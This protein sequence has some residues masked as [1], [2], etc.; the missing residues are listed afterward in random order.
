MSG[1]KIFNYKT[2]QIDELLTYQNPTKLRGNVYICN[3]DK[4]F[5]ILIQTKDLI[6]K[7]GIVENDKEAYIELD[8]RGTDLQ[9]F[10][11]NIDKY[12]IN[13]VHTK[14]KE[15][16]DQEVPYESIQEFYISNLN[17]GILKIA[18]P[19]VRKKIEI[20]VFDDK[21][22]AVDYKDLKDGSKVV[23]CF[24][25][26]GLKFLKKQCIMGIDVIQ[27]MHMR[28]RDPEIMPSS[29]VIQ[30]QPISNVDYKNE[31]LNRIQFRERLKEKKEE[32]RLAFEE[33]EKTQLLADSL[34]EKASLL[35][36]E[37]KQI[38]DEYYKEDEEIEEE[39]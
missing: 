36:R 30:K 28:H 26:N 6:L 33:A 25:I 14:C 15:W 27:I 39:E 24:R 12:N 5:D 9:T 31:M 23:L 19:Y 11:E 8:V 34:K 17:N 29:E 3:P 2:F 13:Y 37:L 38:E 10:I 20:K 7:S 32:A 18:I 22:N 21:K 35:A 16:F 1:Y 4:P